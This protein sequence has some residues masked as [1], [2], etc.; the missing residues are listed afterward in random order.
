M[1]TI[2]TTFLTLALL[3]TFG[4]MNTVG[5]TEIVTNENI[6]NEAIEE[7]IEIENWMLS[8]AAWDVELIV[9]AEAEITV[10]NWM[11][12]ADRENWNT[13]VTVEAEKEMEVEA[14]MNDLSVW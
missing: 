4:L 3:V 9:D 8:L 13:T 5:A 12:R 1:K 11:V 10:E 14:W 7:S 6:N 2:Y